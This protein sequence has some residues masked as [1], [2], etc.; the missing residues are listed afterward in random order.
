MR[1][2][3]SWRAFQSPWVAAALVLVG[4]PP[5]AQFGLVSAKQKIS[6]TAGGFGGDLDLL[7]FFGTSAAGLGDLDGDGIADLAVG[8]PFD[9]DGGLGLEQGAVWI[10]FLDPDGTVASHQKISETAGGFLGVLDKDDHFGIS[11]AA[12][13][14]LNGDGVGDLAVGANLDDDGGSNQGAVWILF[15]NPDGTVSAHQRISETSGNLGGGLDPSDGFGISVAALGD[16]DGD[17]VGDL[18][19]GANLDDDGGTDQGALWILFLNTDGTVESKQKI[20][21]LQGGFTGHLDLVDLF[22]RSVAALGDLDGDGVEDVA[23]G[24][25]LD[26]DGASDQGAVW[27]LFLNSNGTVASHRKLSETA[28]GF[29]GVLDP[30]DFFGISLAAL[31]LDGDGTRDLAV[32]ASLDDDGNEADGEGAVWLLFLDPQGNVGGQQKISETQGGLGGVLHRGDQF[33]ISLAALGDLDG[34]GDGD[35]AV[36]AAFDDDGGDDQGALWILFLV[37]DTTPPTLGCPAFV[38]SL[39]RRG[40]PPGETVFFSVTASDD[41][42]PAP[43]VVCVPPSGSFFPR[44][45]SVVLCTA[46]DATGNQATCTFPVVVSEHYRSARR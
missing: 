38:S 19:V 44:G 25:P 32:G 30:N 34:D 37:G 5:E 17:G 4:A 29:T 7:D 21:A 13:G 16:L 1:R 15:L 26:D 11:V 12:L 46:T 6:E 8:A 45:T 23:V 36:G 42:D 27:I 2:S 9:D 40:G 3:S 43:T 35:L 10:L 18:A 41:S 31:D 14:D 33:G 39:D 20:S 22:G 28:G 24:A